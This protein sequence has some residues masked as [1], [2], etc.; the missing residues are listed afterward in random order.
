MAPYVKDSFFHEAEVTK[1]TLSAKNRYLS[2][3]R[4]IE[5][6]VERLARYFDCVLKRLFH[7]Y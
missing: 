6:A 3:R 1:N 7:E 5:R 2:S 4:I